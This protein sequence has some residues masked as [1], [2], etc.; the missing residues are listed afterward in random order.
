MKGWTKPGE[1]AKVAG[2]SRSAVSQWLGQGSKEIRSLSI[3]AAQ[4]LARATGY[5]F[6]WIALGEGPKRATGQVPYQW[7]FPGVS[8]DKV[9]ALSARQIAHLEGLLLASAKLLGVDVVEETAPSSINLEA[10]N[11]RG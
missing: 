9:L 7:P 8:E 6:K 3:Q 4:R 11:R 1:V 10:A 2:V 5:E